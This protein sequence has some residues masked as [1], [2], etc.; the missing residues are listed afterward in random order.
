MWGL[1]LWGIVVVFAWPAHAR[2]LTG[3]DFHKDCRE[4]KLV[5]WA[6]VA[7]VTDKAEL[8][9]AFANDIPSPDV[10]RSKPIRDLASIIRPYCLPAQVSL[11]QATD[12]VC[13][14]LKEKPDVRHFGGASI[15]QNALREAL[16][17]R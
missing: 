11:E 16:P 1:V 12:I 4:N 3:N 5:V 14:Y 6:Y 10:D 2:V 9:K 13:K 15:V 17:C 7:G 8:D